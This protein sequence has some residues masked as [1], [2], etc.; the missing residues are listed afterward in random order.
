M[1]RNLDKKSQEY[2]DGYN[3]GFE[4]GYDEAEYDLDKENLLNEGYEAGYNDAKKETISPF[5][6]V[7]LIRETNA[8][9]LKMKNR[10]AF[11]DELAD[12]IDRTFGVYQ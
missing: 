7:R 9:Y 5:D 1:L 12:A 11:D 6:I 4:D 10:P 8:Y 2:I 3:H